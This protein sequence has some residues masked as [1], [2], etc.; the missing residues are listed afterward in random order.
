MVQSKHT[1]PRDP[2]WYNSRKYSRKYNSRMLMKKYSRKYN[3]EVLKDAFEE[4]QVKEVCYT[5][6]ND[7]LI[8]VLEDVLENVLEK[9]QLGEVSTKGITAQGSTRKYTRVYSWNHSKNYPRK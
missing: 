1:A 9:V 7:V 4:V 8:Y 3:S 5:V 2:T 6:L